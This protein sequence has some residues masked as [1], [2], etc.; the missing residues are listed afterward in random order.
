MSPQSARILILTLA[1]VAAA[2]LI[3]IPSTPYQL[4]AIIIAGGAPRFRWML[5]RT[6]EQPA[7]NRGYVK[8][9]RWAESHLLTES[10]RDDP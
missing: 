9:L 8:A 1:A 5:Q 6:F 7:E 3:N 2:L 4:A 10:D